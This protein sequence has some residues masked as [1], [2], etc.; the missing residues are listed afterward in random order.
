M[1][2]KIQPEI[3]HK[4]ENLYW[5]LVGKIA[6]LVSNKIIVV[7]DSDKKDLTSEGYNPKKMSIIPIGISSNFLREYSKE[8]TSEILNRYNLSSG[9]Y[10]I[11][12]GHLTKKKN[13]EFAD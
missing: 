11:Q 9:N 4:L 7:S 8:K 10:L 13:Q 3:H 6:S 5:R 12:V 1:I 2:Y